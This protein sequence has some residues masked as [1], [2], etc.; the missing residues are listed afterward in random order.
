[1][2]IL[3]NSVLIMEEWVLY[4]FVG[5]C[6]KGCVGNEIRWPNNT[7]NMLNNLNSNKFK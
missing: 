4:K 7:V 6:I 1:M 5:R 2:I 3:Q